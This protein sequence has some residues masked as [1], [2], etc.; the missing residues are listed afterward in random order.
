[1]TGLHLHAMAVP[2]LTPTEALERSEGWGFCGLELIID[3]DYRC[4]VRVDEAEATLRQ[5]RRQAIDRGLDIPVVSSYERGLG[6]GDGTHRAAARDRLR[7]EMDVA[8]TLD[9]G[10]LRILAGH[11]TTGVHPPLV[12]DL[13]EVADQ[14]P[15]G[16]R[17]L[18][19]N[20]MGTAVETVAATVELVSAVDRP[21]VR[22]IADPANLELCAPGDSADLVRQLPWTRHLHVKDFLRGPSIDRR[23][24]VIPGDG[25]VDWAQAFATIARADVEVTMTFE[26]EARWFHEL[27]SVHLVAREVLDRVARWR[28]MAGEV[29]DVG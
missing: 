16:L 24:P 8:A 15:P 6:V 14:A 1:M 3:D 17:L 10:G 7:R 4:A 23:R 27:P 28:R 13:A 26:Y 29:L 18:V 25:D 20:H 21:G 11:P 19:E 2:D 5:L 9:A 22:V 12:E